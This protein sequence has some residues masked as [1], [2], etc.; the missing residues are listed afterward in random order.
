MAGFGLG[1]YINPGVGGFIDQ[2]RNALAGLGAGLLN[3]QPGAGVQQGLQADNAYAVQQKAEAERQ[4]AIADQQALRSK[5]ADFFNQQGQPDIAQAIADGIVEPGQ[6]YWD[7]ITPKQ[8]DP[9]KGI[10]ING[11][12][13]N[14]QTGEP[15]GD[16]RSPPTGPTTRTL[17]PEETQQM[18]LPTGSYQQDADGKI[19]Q[20]GG[21]RGGMPSATLQ[22][23]IFEADEGV[24]AGQNVMRALDTALELNKTA[25]DGP[26]ADITSQGAALFGNPEAVQTQELKNIVTANALESLKATFGAAPTEGERRILLDIQG[27]VTQSRPVREAIFK[28]AKAAAERRLKF[29]AEKA[30]GLRSGDYFDEGYSPASPTG[31]FADPIAAADALLN[32]GKY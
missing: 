2:R 31:S 30:R 9:V 5:Y 20:I 17:T 24:Q 7:F 13:V 16:F 12:L 27:S 6:A 26:A 10:E 14:P 21:A 23:E 4:K 11:Q 32:S 29:N 8:S 3:G 22:K 18:G 15:M 19:S 25:W 28:R 1:N